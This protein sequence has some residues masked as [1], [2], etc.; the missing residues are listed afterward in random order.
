LRRIGL[1]S[2]DIAALT[3]AQW[4]LWLDFAS[5]EETMESLNTELRAIRFM[6][7]ADEKSVNKGIDRLRGQM[8]RLEAWFYGTE[9]KT[10]KLRR[11]W[12]AQR[13]ET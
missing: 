8:E 3:E 10:D 4:A 12:R 1:T 2:G 5:Y 9:T 11:T 13:G 7:M 6:P